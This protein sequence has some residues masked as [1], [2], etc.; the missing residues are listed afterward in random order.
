LEYLGRLDQ[1][2]KVLGHRIEPAEVEAA[3]NQHPAVRE[4]LVT[5]RADSSGQPQ[6]VAYLL[7]RPD[8]PLPEPARLAEFLHRLLPAYMVP[9]A[10][11]VL[12]AWPLTAHGKIDRRNLPAPVAA[13]AGGRHVI[14]PRPGLETIVAGVWSEVLGRVEIGAGDDFFRLGGHSLRAA[15][16]IS[17]LNAALNVTL[18][19]RHLFEHSTIAGLAA[20]IA[21]FQ[22]STDSAAP[23]PARTELAEAASEP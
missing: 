2:V 1:Q 16:V 22:P 19:V 6:L 3:L 20:A 23:M 15:Q 8:I 4:C 17:R 18:S 14:A 10:Y 13:E 11:S 12:D 5:T 21:R 9:A 7:A